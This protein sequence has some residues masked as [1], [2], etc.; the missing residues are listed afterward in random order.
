M[1]DDG[2]EIDFEDLLSETLNSIEQHPGHAQVEAEIQRR[3]ALRS[4]AVPTKDDDVRKRLRELREPVTLF[5]ERPGDRRDRLKQIVSRQ[6]EAKRQ[7]GQD[8]DMGDVSS[9]SSDDS[10]GDGKE[11][12]FFTPGGP[13]LLAERKVTAGF[14]L[15]R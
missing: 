10:D 4:L 1:S 12:E 6:L 11:E 3:T 8:V 15:R 14:S 2:N 13:A 5:G 7:A 9:S